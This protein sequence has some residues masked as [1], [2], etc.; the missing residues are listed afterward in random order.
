MRT[1][2]PASTSPATPGAPVAPPRDRTH[3]LYLA[4]IAAVA[5]GVAVGF[6]APDVAVELKWLGTVFVSL[7]KMMISP[8]IFCTIVLGI[9]SVRQAAR[10]GKV[11]GLALA[12]FV[13]MSTVALAVGLVVGNLVQPGDGLHL[14]TAARRPWRSSRAAAATPRRSP[15]TPCRRPT[16]RW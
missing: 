13:A 3:L 1:R 4:V 2:M 12:Y 14:T 8:V 10:I 16:A 15:T 11:G 5:L 7:V 6:V 9:G